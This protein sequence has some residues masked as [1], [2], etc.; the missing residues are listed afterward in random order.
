M[1]ALAYDGVRVIGVDQLPEKLT[2]AR[3]SGAHEA[4]TPDEAAEAGDQGGGGDRGGRPPRARWRP[5]SR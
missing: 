2:G 1:T 5:R 4:Y 3:L